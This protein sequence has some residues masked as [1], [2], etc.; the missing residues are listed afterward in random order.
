MIYLDY[1]KETEKCKKNIFILYTK[2]Y[3][4]LYIDKNIESVI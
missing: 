1:A 3:G 4:Y 2:L